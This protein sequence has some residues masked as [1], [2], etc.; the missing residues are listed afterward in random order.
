[1]IVTIVNIHDNRLNNVVERCIYAKQQI[2]YKQINFQIDML[3]RLRCNLHMQMLCRKLKNLFD[4]LVLHLFDENHLF[5]NEFNSMLLPHSCKSISNQ[6]NRFR[7]SPS[8][9]SV[10]LIKCEMWIWVKYNLNK[11]NRINWAIFH[12]CAVYSLVAHN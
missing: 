12:V 10:F 9:S 3:L 8:I 4:I 7:L 11:I 1:M 2:Y 6:F 5:S